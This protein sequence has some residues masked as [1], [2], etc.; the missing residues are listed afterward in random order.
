MSSRVS[1]SRVEA[2][3]YAPPA[4]L[5][6]IVEV[7]WSG[8][9]DLTGQAPH[10]TQL[11][12]DPAVHLV[13]EAGAGRIVGVWTR[14]W[15]RTLQGRGAVR[16][17]KLRPGAVRALL[18]DPARA[19][20]DRITPLG[21]VFDAIGALCG[22]VLDPRDDGLAFAALA[23]WIRARARRDAKVA[24]AV[25]ITQRIRGSGIT[26]VEAL[27]AEAGLTVR[28]LQRLFHDHVGASPKWVIRWVRLQ[29]VALRIEA[30]EAPDLADLAYQLGYADQAHLA[31]DFRATTGQTLRGFE[32][33]V[34]R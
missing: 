30:G 18:P 21:E 5:A 19:Y 31:R 4:D 6:D 1:G 9:W 28:A 32:D 23:D 8:A 15:T 29:E 24:R 2:H 27:A 34:H 17:V 16:G 33:A 25:E 10:T 14:L 22:A 11:I 20:S 26:R 3:S 7:F 13:F 12:A